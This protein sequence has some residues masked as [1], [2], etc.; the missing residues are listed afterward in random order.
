MPNAPG[1]ACALDSNASSMSNR[2]GSRNGKRR[3]K[4]LRN[5]HGLYPLLGAVIFSM[6]LIFNFNVFIKYVDV[7][8]KRLYPAANGFT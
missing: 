8:V 3:Y 6:F 4:L 1:K 7:V 2:G 5:A